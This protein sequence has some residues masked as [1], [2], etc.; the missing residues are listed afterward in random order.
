MET[1]KIGRNEFEIKK[2]D[3]IYFNGVLYLFCA[4]DNRALLI[5]GFDKYTSLVISKKALSKLSLKTMD[6]ITTNYYGKT[7][8]KWIFN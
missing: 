3:Y 2:G 1:I 7:H 8:I 6:K 5:K 4:G